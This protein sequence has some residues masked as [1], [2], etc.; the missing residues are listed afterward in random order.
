MMSNRAH[1]APGPNWT[2]HGLRHTATFLMSDD[3]SMPP[4]HVQHIPGHKHL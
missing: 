3:Q 4:V 2:L 1:E